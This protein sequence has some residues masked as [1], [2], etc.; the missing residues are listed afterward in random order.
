MRTVFE[1]EYE[2]EGAGAPARRAR[3]G[4]GQARMA[5]R[6]NASTS[7]PLHSSVTRWAPVGAPA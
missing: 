4:T 7:D 3:Q 6:H 5:A 1:A 2:G